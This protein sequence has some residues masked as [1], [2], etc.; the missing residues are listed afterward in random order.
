MVTN[1]PE[2]NRK[3]DA[4]SEKIGKI[5]LD[6]EIIKDRDY[7]GAIREIERRLSTAEADFQKFKTRALTVFA[8]V[9]IALGAVWTFLS[10]KLKSLF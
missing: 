7:A 6:V 10:D 2:I 5:H 8:A 4:L 9:Q 3:L 1:E